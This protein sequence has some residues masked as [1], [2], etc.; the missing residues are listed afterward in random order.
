MKSL[1]V[2]LFFTFGSLLFGQNITLDKSHARLQFFVTHMTISTVDGKFNEFDVVL[3]NF[4]QNDI[5]KSTITVVAQTNSIDTGI[6]AR[7][8]HLKSADFFDVA[9]YKTIEF[10]STSL[11]KIIGNTYKLNGNLTMSGVTK[12]ITLTLVYNGNSINS[13]NNIKS[14]GFTIKGTI[15]RSSY[16]IGKKFP[17]S[18]IGNDIKILS[19]LEFTQNKKKK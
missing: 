14:Y 15:N 1:I 10:K 5:T 8:N 16:E 11:E 19:N 13:A 2:G 7:D 4:D 17:E 9:Q 3:N 12:P 18:V 6:E